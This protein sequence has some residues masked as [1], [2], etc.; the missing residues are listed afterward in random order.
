MT[1][2]E[3]KTIVNQFY[4]ELFNKKNLDYIEEVTASEFVDHNPEPDQAPGVEG[5]KQVFSMFSNAFPDMSVNIDLQVAEGDYVASRI[6]IKGT[7]TGEMRGMPAT[8]KQVTVTGVDIMR[9]QDGKCIERWGDF[10]QLGM[11]QQ[12]GVIPEPQQTTE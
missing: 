3:N 10:D 9:F 5:V 7:N 12:L 4:D 6:T 11:M 2:E 8:N 1:P